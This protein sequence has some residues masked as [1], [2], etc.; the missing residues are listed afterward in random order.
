MKEITYYMT[1]SYGGMEGRTIE[2][3]KFETEE[4]AKK[5]AIKDTW[6]TDFT[7]YKVT[8]IFNGKIT[9][10]TE[11]VGKIECGREIEKRNKK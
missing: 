4:A 3:R 10:K 1:T 11:I 6:N 7:M 5:D 2:R 9:E 8:M